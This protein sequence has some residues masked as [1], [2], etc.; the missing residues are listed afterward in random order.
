VWLAV[1]AAI[2]VLI[3]A[4]ALVFRRRRVQTQVGVDDDR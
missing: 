4:G 2:A 3:A 1:G